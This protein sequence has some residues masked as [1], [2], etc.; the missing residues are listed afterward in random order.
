MSEKLKC[1][2]DLNTSSG[3]SETAPVVSIPNKLILPDRMKPGFMVGPPRTLR[4]CAPFAAEIWKREKKSQ[5]RGCRTILDAREVLH[6]LCAGLRIETSA[7]N[8]SPGQRAG[9]LRD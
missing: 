8:L 7:R 3:K 6:N 5:I 2:A 1:Y 4:L 9:F